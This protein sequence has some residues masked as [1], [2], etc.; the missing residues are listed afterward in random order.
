LNVPHV[1]PTDYLQKPDVKISSFFSLHRPISV[2]SAVP[3]VSTSATFDSIFQINPGTSRR[4]VLNN[5]QTLSGG[6]ESLE[7]AL[8][9]QDAKQEDVLSEEPHVKHLDGVPRLSVDQMLSRFI[10][11]SPPPPP[12]PFDQATAESET[13]S[14]EASPEVSREQPS[15]VAKKAWSATVV[16]TESTDST[17]H[18]T[19]STSTTPLKEAELPSAET[20]EM[21]EIQI[22]QP[23][24]DRM[25]QRDSEYTRY[26]D[27]RSGRV[28]S[29]MHLISVK[30]QRRLKMKKHKYK[31]LM[32]R[33]RLLRRKLDRA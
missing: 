6:I 24:L 14:T 16:V 29:D 8:R 32:K 12:V 3:P 25:R 17:G 28:R 33:T 11:F 31:K 5:I 19:Y 2:T 15:I 7:A 22:R 26:R 9:G 23:F 20:A 21:E 10:P 30:R 13:T 27:D 4:G 18:Q 1:P